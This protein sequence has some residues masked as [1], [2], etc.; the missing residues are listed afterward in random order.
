MLR[1]VAAGPRLATATMSEAALC[2]NSTT[3][4]QIESFQTHGFALVTRNDGVCTDDLSAMNTDIL[5]QLYDRKDTWA[6][7]YWRWQNSIATPTNR[8]SLPLPLTASMEQMLARVIT[9]L[10]PLFDSQLDPDSPLVECNALISLP[11]ALA[12]RVHS[13]VPWS[14]SV[15]IISAFVALAPVLLDS[16]PTQALTQRQRT[17]MIGQSSWP[18]SASHSSKLKR[19]EINQRWRG[20]IQHNSHCCSLETCWCSMQGCTT[21]VVQIHRHRLARCSASRSSKQPQT[22]MRASRIMRLKV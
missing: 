1:G 5:Q 7:R 16:G 19:K 8:Y 15:T 17:Q 18:H 6:Y 14:E 22:E 3:A 12:Q 13:D 11:G 9:P 10:R 21:T 20:S 2:Y 4:E